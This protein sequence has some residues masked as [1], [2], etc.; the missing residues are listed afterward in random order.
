MDNKEV[1]N[2]IVQKSKILTSLLIEKDAQKK[3]N[4][5]LASDFVN[6]NQEIT[7]NKNKEK[8]SEKFLEEE[9]NE[10]ATTIQEEEICKCLPNDD[11][12]TDQKDFTFGISCKIGMVRCCSTTKT[13]IEEEDEEDTTTV[14][15]NIDLAD[16]STHS[17][18]ILDT[19]T[20]LNPQTTQ[21]ASNELKPRISNHRKSGQNATLKLPN[22]DLPY[23]R[24]ATPITDTSY[25][26]RIQ[27]R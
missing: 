27:M 11:C 20:P 3:A 21:K 24:Y 1:V 16:E 26:H 18:T 10:A 8:S 2:P 14:N 15:S 19:T 7:S 17:T 22:Q 13:I 12:P 6:T 25:Y 5:R 23:R 4:V 9:K